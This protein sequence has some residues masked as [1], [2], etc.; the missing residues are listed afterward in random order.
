MDG[1]ME[2]SGLGVG[3]GAGSGTPSLNSLLQEMRSFSVKYLSRCD[4]TRIALLILREVAGEKMM[5]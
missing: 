3:G 5:Y 1:P 2:F 4:A